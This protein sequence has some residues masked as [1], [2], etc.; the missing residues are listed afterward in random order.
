MAERPDIV[1][2]DIHLRDEMDGIEAAELIG[3]LLDIP[4]VFLSAYSDPDLLRRAKG[5]GSFGYLVK[6][7]EERA[8][9]AT[10]EMA[11]YRASA[12]EERSR[13]LL[14]LRRSNDALDEFGSIVSH[15]LQEPL[16]TITSYL[17]LLERRYEA[18]FDND[19]AE[20]MKFATDSADRM[21][22]MI[23]SL[24][25]Y[26]RV[27]ARG[28]EFAPVECKDVLADVLADLDVSLSESDGRIEV[29]PL[30]TVMG[31][32]HQ[33]TGLFQ[34]LI[35]NALKFHGEEPPRVEISARRDGRAWTFTVRDNGIGFHPQFA[36]EVF[37][38]FRSLHGEGVY[39]GTGIGLSI[40]RKIVERH[41]GRIWAES[42][43]G[44]GAAFHFTLPADATRR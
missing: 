17:R 40:C 26:A 10:L 34:N 11:L 3:D 29:G 32:H 28:E 8:L 35:G 31:D 25:A 12:E 2:M 42:E 5:V 14:E 20:F 15:D 21:Q 39:E 1:I 38:V 33:L 7:F 19:A 27:G 6:P 30:P 37:V 24:L 36:Q 16:R 13:F 23:Q 41:G 18:L 22:D 44:R 9:H 43:P 4:V